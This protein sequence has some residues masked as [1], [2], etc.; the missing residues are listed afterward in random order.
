M[1]TYRF[2]LRRDTAAN[3]ATV[4]PVLANGEPGYDETNDQLRIGNGTDVW[5]DLPTVGGPGSVS[6]EDDGNFHLSGTTSRVMEG[7]DAD[8]LLP[9]N[10]VLDALT[11]YLD[12]GAKV[13]AL[14][15]GQSRPDGLAA[16]T[17]ILRY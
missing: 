5:S 4:N 6:L 10:T 12:L 17:I 11:E 2:Q 14:P 15:V 7:L 3:W 9:D 16:G 1:P 8:T 13:L